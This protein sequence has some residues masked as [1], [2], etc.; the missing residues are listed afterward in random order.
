MPVL[1]CATGAIGL[2]VVAAV[3]ALL[4]RQIR[5][6]ALPRNH[7][8]GIRTRATLR[9]DAAW[10]AGHR[11]AE[12]LTRRTAQVAAA[13]G[14]LTVLVAAGLEWAGVAESAA[15]PVT[16]AVLGLGYA[17]FLVLTLRLAVLAHRAARAA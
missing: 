10:Q 1:S 9:S 17:V 8:V 4:A 13:A 3:F 11:A 14:A 12:P 15:V 2:W 16:L 5:N 6:D 7:L